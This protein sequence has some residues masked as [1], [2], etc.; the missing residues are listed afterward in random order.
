ME[1]LPIYNIKWR[2]GFGFNTNGNLHTKFVQKT[3]SSILELVEIAL[4]YTYIHA[5]G[6]DLLTE[7]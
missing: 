6:S 1:F 2:I 3:T 4:V 5:D 7:Q